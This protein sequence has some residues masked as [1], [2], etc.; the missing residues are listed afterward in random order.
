MSVNVE[1]LNLSKLNI[2]RPD[3]L[4]LHTLLS[5]INA[6]S[7]R[8]QDV[9]NNH[10]SSESF[11]VFSRMLHEIAKLSEEH[12]YTQVYD[13]VSEMESTVI[14]LGRNL[15]AMQEASN[16]SVVEY[17]SS[18][19]LMLETLCRRLME[20][21]LKQT[22]KD[23]VI[24]TNTASRVYFLDENPQTSQALAVDIKGHGYQVL[25]FRCVD[26]LIHAVRFREPVAILVFLDAESPIGVS[27]ADNERKQ[28]VTEELEL[29]NRQELLLSVMAISNG[30]VPCIAVG[31]GSDMTSRLAAAAAGV[32]SFYVE[33]LPL[34]TLVSELHSLQ[35]TVKVEPLRL[36]LMS[37]VEGRSSLLIERT[38][39]DAHL[40]VTT[41]TQLPALVE[42]LVAGFK[43][44]TPVDVVVLYDHGD[45][46]LLRQCFAL[47]RQDPLLE[48]VPLFVITESKVHYSE[49][50]LR[51]IVL[52]SSGHFSMAELVEQ[53]QVDSGHFESKYAESRY[54]EK[55]AHLLLKIQ[56]NALRYRRQLAI[57]D[58]QKNVEPDSGLLTV[59]GFYQQCG[60][61]LSSIDALEGAPPVMIRVQ[62]IALAR[63]ADE[64]GLTDEVLKRRIAHGLM[65]LLSPMDRVVAFGMDQ[66]SL[67]I[68][69]ADPRRYE[70]LC[71]KIQDWIAHFSA[72]Y[73]DEVMLGAL[74]GSGTVLFG[75]G[76]NHASLNASLHAAERDAV[77]AIHWQT[78]P[79]D[80]E[81]PPQFDTITENMGGNIKQA[82]RPRRSPLGESVTEVPDVI[83]SKTRVSDWSERIKQAIKAKRLSLVYQPIVSL[84]M[85]SYERYE[86]LLRL[87]EEG[88]VITPREFLGVMSDSAL[89]SY[90]D[91]WVVAT[92]L[93]ELRQANRINNHISVFFIKLTAKTIADR[94]FVPWLKKAFDGSGID[95]AQCVFELPE[96]LLLASFAESQDAIRRLRELGAKVSISNFGGSQQSLSILEYFEV[97]FVKLDRRFT[98][99]ENAGEWSDQLMSLL[100]QVTIRKVVVLAGFVEN[101]DSLLSVI[102]KGVG[103]VSGDFLQPP[104]AERQFDF[105]INL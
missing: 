55:V 58:Y 18:C 54:A 43:Q 56:S 40:Q 47:L 61:V 63:F 7:L 48:A 21:M 36:L 28:N 73:A 45:E 89:V 5:E 44:S 6:L 52:G 27:Q 23:A 41:V 37:D 72:Q 25:S 9:L 80:T 62:V 13:V 70:I 90:I 8:W 91:R 66:F 34:V 57:Q 51:L 69:Q 26:D 30:R 33:P 84:G 65:S 32:N 105:A 12:R 94:S 103:L 102:Q 95:P 22:E 4:S 101:T 98:V 2:D 31:R 88:K 82:D 75:S 74:V 1:A 10:F 71:Q 79:S 46:V 14:A 35:H 38:L 20:E 86:V 77:M 100:Q 85:D 64:I 59:T 76:S 15:G 92:A 19:V 39:V 16:G 42:H 68:A 67:F 50:F 81:Q 17:M 78:K 29:I 87:N 83:T 99:Q 97:D 53:E 96:A 49:H 11:T 104:D 93:K 60:R 3:H 24:L